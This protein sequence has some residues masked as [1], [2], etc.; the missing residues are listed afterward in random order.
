MLDI[1]KL[2]LGEV[3]KIEELSGQS[4]AAI[5]EENSPKGKT[6]AAM[7]FVAKRREQLAA[8]ETAT[9][10]W[11]EALGLTFEEANALIGINAD[12]E[13][14]DDVEE[15]SADPLDVT[16]PSPSSPRTRSKK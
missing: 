14:Q 8:G 13:D 11:N 9:F 6:L 2:T 15:G 16:V 7:A 5:G 3:A 4:I 12:D 10:T 1:S